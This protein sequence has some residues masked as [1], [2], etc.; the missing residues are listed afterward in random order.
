MLTRDDHLDYVYPSYTDNETFF[1]QILYFLYY[2]T[3]FL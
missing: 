3:G 1:V 2:I